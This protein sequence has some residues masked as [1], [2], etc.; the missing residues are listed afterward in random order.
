MPRNSFRATSPI[1]ESLLRSR[2]APRPL[3][4]VLV[5]LGRLRLQLRN[6]RSEAR[7]PLARRWRRRGGA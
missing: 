6:L 2:S 5:V 3:A 4:R 7:A 1:L